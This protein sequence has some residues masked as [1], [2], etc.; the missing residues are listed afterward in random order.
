MHKGKSGDHLLRV[1][2]GGAGQPLEVALD[3]PA[4]LPA[5]VDRQALR[6]VPDDVQ[7]REAEG[8]L[9]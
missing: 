8:R 7:D 6:V 3:G 2:L 9:H 5:E 4:L 1:G